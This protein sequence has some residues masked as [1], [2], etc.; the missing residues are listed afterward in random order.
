MTRRS[1]TARALDALA[2]ACQADAEE[3]A[4]LVD[5]ARERAE[6]VAA[7]RGANGF[8]SFMRR[9]ATEFETIAAGVREAGA[10]RAAEL[11]GQTPRPQQIEVV[12]E[13]RVEAV[14]EARRAG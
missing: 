14:L 13:D 4:G 3:I 5:A 12:H 6:A 10:T 2:A 1:R 7:E 9:K 11:R 8:A